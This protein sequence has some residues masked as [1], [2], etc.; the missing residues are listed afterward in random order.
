MHFQWDEAYQ[1]TFDRLKM[2]LI[3][4]VILAYSDPNKDYR[5]Y[6]DI[7]DQLIGACLSQERG[8]KNNLFFCF[9]N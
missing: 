3:E 1:A 5:L 2:K 7:S 6:T 4:M 8:R 9:I